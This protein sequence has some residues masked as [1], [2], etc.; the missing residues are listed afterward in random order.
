MEKPR[1]GEELVAVPFLS[2]IAP[3]DA[4]VVVEE[5]VS[6]SIV[7]AGLPVVEFAA[8]GR[9]VE[10]LIAPASVVANKEASVKERQAGGALSNLEMSPCWEWMCWLG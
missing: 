6:G 10:P 8:P 2:D 4:G 1:N 9:A 7:G 3:A 5:L